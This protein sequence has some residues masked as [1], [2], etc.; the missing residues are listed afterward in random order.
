MTCKVKKVQTLF[1][2]LY[3]MIPVREL[4]LNTH[5]IE[6]I[7]AIEHQ[8]RGLLVNETIANKQNGN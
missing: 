6:K 5:L 2:Q 4:M 8:L 1:R 7:E 3:G